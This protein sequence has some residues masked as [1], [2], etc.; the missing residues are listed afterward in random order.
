M[1]RIYGGYGDEPLGRLRPT[2]SHVRVSPPERAVAELRCYQGRKRGRLLGHVV[3][4]HDGF[5][6]LAGTPNALPPGPDG[7]R[8]ILPRCTCEA[9]HV[10]DLDKVR[11]TARY[12][13][14]RRGLPVVDVST[15]LHPQGF[16]Q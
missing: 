5:I 6:I 12:L 15:V 7:R 9:R 1:S 14:R 3:D 13:K 16:L 8:V 2:N 11:R 10:L 4:T